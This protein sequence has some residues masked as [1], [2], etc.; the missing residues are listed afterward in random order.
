MT[1]YHFGNCLALAC[2]PYI[3]TYKYSMLSEYSAFW[4]CVKVGG[5][6]IVTQFCKMLLLAT[7]FPVDSSGE[8]FDPSTELM[9]AT[10]D[11]GDVIGIYFV[12]SKIS[13]KGEMKIL[14]TG[15]GWSAAELATTRLI[16]LWV[17][18]RGTEF[19]WN[20]MLMSFDAN[21]CLVHYLTVAALLWVL[22]RPDLNKAFR[23][24]VVGLLLITC[25]KPVI[26]RLLSL[27][28]LLTSLMSLFVQTVVVC[29][30]GAAALCLLRMVSYG[31]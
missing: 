8:R 1:L 15:L 20:Y 31:Q 24:A 6:Y 17:G 30:L 5:A 3:I 16:P 9:K 14:V 28:V 18:A 29:G 23:P 22:T 26:L 10:M 25:Y 11:I 4:K 27:S 13:G 19:N 21:I 2:G 12:L 7:F